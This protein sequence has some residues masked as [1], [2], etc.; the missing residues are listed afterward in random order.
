MWAQPDA[1]ELAHLEVEVGDVGLRLA[2]HADRR[3]AL[4][5]LVMRTGYARRRPQ[6]GAPVSCGTRQQNDF[7]GEVQR[8]KSDDPSPPAETA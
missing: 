2:D 4:C 3:V 5:R 7:R 6:P 1:E 8:S